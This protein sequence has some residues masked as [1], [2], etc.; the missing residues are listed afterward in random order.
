M[1]LRLDLPGHLY[2][3]FDGFK[4]GDTIVLSG[5][6]VTSRVYNGGSSG[7]TLALG[8]GG[9]ATADLAFA[10]GHS[11]G[12][13]SIDAVGGDTDITVPCFVE[14]TRIATPE[15]SVPVEALRPGDAVL[16]VAGAGAPVRWVGHRHVD[17]RGHTRPDDV[18]PVRIVAG[19]FGGG[20]PARDLLLSPDHS[21]LVEYELIPIRYLVNG[22][23]VRQEEKL[24][25]LPIGTSSCHAT[26][27]C[28]RKGFRAKATST[29]AIAAASPMA[30]G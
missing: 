19:A 16:T 24:P 22:A 18:H 1:H 29:P 5:A 7:G 30:L 2:G 9:G 13:F 6:T 26:T 17:C 4:G 28:W 12:S 10:G 15:G 14:G 3:T 11:L 23:T 21:V 27:C 25:A 20:R 8:I